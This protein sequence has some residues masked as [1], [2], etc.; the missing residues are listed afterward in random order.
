MKNLTNPP[1]NKVTK[2]KKKDMEQI[3]FR[4]W[5]TGSDR[6]V[7]WKDVQHWSFGTVDWEQYKFLQFTGLKDKNGVE[8]Y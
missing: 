2:L 5:D 7:E 8:V 3:K 6:M 4:V 1:P